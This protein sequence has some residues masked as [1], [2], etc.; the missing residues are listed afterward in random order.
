MPA[1]TRGDH[2]QRVIKVGQIING[3]QAGSMALWIEGG[4]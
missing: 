2:K 1:L 3:A 4:R